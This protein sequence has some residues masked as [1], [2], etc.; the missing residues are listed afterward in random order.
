MHPRERVAEI[1][2]REQQREELAQRNHQSDGQRRAFRRQHIHAT[3][4]Q[5]LRQN[6]PDQI[7]THDWNRNFN[8]GDLVRRA[9]ERYLQICEDI[10]VE[11]RET[12]QRHTVRVEQ[13]F[14]RVFPVRPV[15]PLLINPHP[16]GNEQRQS[17][18]R[19]S[20]GP[21]EQET[22]IVHLRNVS[23]G[24]IGAYFRLAARYDRTYT[25]PERYHRHGYVFR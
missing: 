24:A 1:Q 3:Y 23:I 17:Q 13:G 11:N 25:N 5:I 9:T 18:Q 14:F 10:R 6:I 15:Q 8:D 16:G 22:I 7:Q 4:T 2:N 21:S 20:D 12:R 19:Y